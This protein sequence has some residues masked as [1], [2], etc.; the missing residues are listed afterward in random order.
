[1]SQ[2]GGRGDASCAYRSLWTVSQSFLTWRFLTCLLSPTSL[3][4]LLLCSPHRRGNSSRTHS[5]APNPVLWTRNAVLPRWP[6]K[7]L[8]D[9][10]FCVACTTGFPEGFLVSAP[11]PQALW[12]LP[13]QTDSSFLS[14]F[15]VPPERLGLLGGPNRSLRLTHCFDNLIRPILL[16][17]RI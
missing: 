16:P 12:A 11:L 15:A 6:V 4:K 3:R 14:L 2:H 7:C 8:C 10:S 9:A 5:E 1:M 17:R 13:E